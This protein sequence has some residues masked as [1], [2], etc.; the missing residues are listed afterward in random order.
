MM[1]ERYLRIIATLPH[2]SRY[3]PAEEGI[4]GQRDRGRKGERPR[5][6]DFMVYI[7][8]VRGKRERE[9]ER[10]YEGRRDLIT[11]ESKMRDR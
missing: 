9:T 3:S 10:M 2:A 8:R 5:T 4:E 1:S 7:N 11:F 6:A